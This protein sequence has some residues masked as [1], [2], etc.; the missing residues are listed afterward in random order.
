M[1]V[2]IFDD[3]GGGKTNFCLFF[4][5]GNFSFEHHPTTK[6]TK[7]NCYYTCSGHMTFIENSSSFG[8][9]GALFFLTSRS[10]KEEHEKAVKEWKD[11]NG[12]PYIILYNKCDNKV[13]REWFYNQVNSLNR[14]LS[15][16]IYGIS[17]LSRYNLLGVFNKIVELF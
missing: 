10:S 7:Y 8:G 14:P 15:C 2:L 6:E 17:A 4:T 9:N 16:P 13:E 11:K 12:G 1:K 3:S 5:D